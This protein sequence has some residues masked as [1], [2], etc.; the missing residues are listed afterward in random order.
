[1][2]AVE[3]LGEESLHVNS[4]VK[5]ISQ[6][7]ILDTAVGNVIGIAFTGIVSSIVADIV[8]PIVSNFVQEDLS[9]SYFVMKKGKDYPYESYGDAMK[10][11]SAIVI[12]YGSLLKNIIQFLIQ[13]FV[14]Y[15]I[16]KTLY[17][18]KNSLKQSSNFFTKT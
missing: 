17:T 11:K 3:Q 15:Y 16:V 5:F 9:E 13:A 1:M 8:T 7:R 2:N 12:K 4:L 6:G 18:A 10:D 14:V